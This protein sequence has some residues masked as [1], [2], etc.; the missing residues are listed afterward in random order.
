M[1]VDTNVLID[2]L[3]GREATLNFLENYIG[4]LKISVI[5]E[6]ELID[7]LRAKKDIVSLD[8]DLFRPLQM[9]IVQINEEISK[10]AVDFFTKYRHSHGI[11]INDAIIAATSLV[12]TEPM[13][14]FN[15]KHFAFIPI[16]KIVKIS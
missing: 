4:L 7:G 15:T 8:K 12:Y 10:K 3:R 6:L 16:L 2:L 14:T 5:V 9:E 13:S 1:F 11:S